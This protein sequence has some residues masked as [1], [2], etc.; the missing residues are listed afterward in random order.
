MSSELTESKLT[1][2][3]ICIRYIRE[4]IQVAYDDWC[5]C[6]P[7]KPEENESTKEAYSHL[8]VCIKEFKVWLFGYI[9]FIEKI[10]PDQEHRQF[11]RLL[12]ATIFFLSKPIYRGKNEDGITW[13]SYLDKLVLPKT[14]LFDSFQQSAY[15][16]DNILSENDY[17]SIHL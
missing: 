8:Q 17:P 2:Y 15:T 16:D 6:N 7:E 14:N 5:Y 10:D 11:K 9:Q 13:I 3:A 1:P 12:Q 4:F